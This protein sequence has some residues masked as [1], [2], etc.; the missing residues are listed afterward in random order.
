MKLSVITINYNNREGLAR[1]LHSVAGQKLS[2]A[3]KCEVEHIVVDGGSTDGST[4]AIEQ[5]APNLSS[6]VSEPDHGI[7]NAMNKG[8][9]MAKGEYVNFMNSGDT[10][11]S[12]DVLAAVLPLLDGKDFYIG[13]QQNT[14]EKTNRILAPQE[15]SAALLL[16]KA[17]SHQ[18]AF[19]RTGLLRKRPYREDLRLVSD[20][21]QMLYEM[22]F[23]NASYGLLDF[24]VADFDTTGA[25]HQA[26]NRRIYQEETEKV[27]RELLPPRMHT[28]VTG[29]GNRYLRKIN[30]AEG[31]ENALRRDWKILRNA[32]KLLLSDLLHR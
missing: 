1:T 8:I 32:V 17:L 22:V 29:G 30:M 20:W 11:H 9:A 19:I 27:L 26:R 25:S 18:S 7:F 5:N 2:D 15:V 16:H 10:F 13:H 24:V 12:P 23:N 4:A 6:W 31:N 21:E 14:G 3:Q 28:F